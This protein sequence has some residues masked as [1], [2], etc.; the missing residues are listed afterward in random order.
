MPNTID[1]I[2]DD[3]LIDQII[4]K[5]ITEIEDD[6]ILKVGYSAF[7]GCADLTS[8]KLTAAT[9]IERLAFNTCTKL[10]SINLPAATSIGN[11]AF[12]GC[13]ALASVNLPAV[14]SIGMSFPDCAKLTD[15]YLSAK[16][17]EISGAPWGATRATIHYE[18][19]FSQDGGE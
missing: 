4:S 15:I 10:A 13:Y 11:N 7:R 17:G 18:Y 1:I 9:S 6:A 16:E 2:G 5:T 8:V 19:D 12:G 3:A 14:T